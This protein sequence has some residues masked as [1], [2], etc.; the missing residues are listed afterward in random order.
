MGPPGA[1][2]L[3]PCRSPVP[4]LLQRPRQASDVV[5][6]MDLGLIDLQPGGTDPCLPGRQE[7]E[8]PRDRQ[9]APRRQGSGEARRERSRTPPRG[10]EPAGPRVGDGYY[11]GAMG[12]A[13]PFGAY[14]PAVSS[15]FARPAHTRRPLQRPSPIFV[16][17]PQA[18]FRTS[19]GSIR[20]ASRYSTRNGRSIELSPGLLR[21]DCR[22]VARNSHCR[23]TSLR[24]VGTTQHQASGSHT[25][26]TIDSF[27]GTV[28]AALF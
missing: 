27:T 7:L 21:R 3:R 10:A 23:P 24:R 25:P 20:S 4:G 2:S 9:G 11:R 6:R 12:I 15:S 8:R 16:I 17:R 18:A 28:V 26:A 22:Q 19:T 1:V 14:R 5:Q 13:M